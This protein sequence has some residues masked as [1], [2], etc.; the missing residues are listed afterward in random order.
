MVYN[1][2][3]VVAIPLVLAL[4]AVV[5]STQTLRTYSIA[6]YWEAWKQVVSIYQHNSGK[7]YSI[8]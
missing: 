3:L 5:L 4:L 1:Q 6:Y 7:V 2:T 8:T